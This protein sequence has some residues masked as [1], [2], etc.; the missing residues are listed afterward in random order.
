MTEQ[1]QY[2]EIVFYHTNGIKTIMNYDEENWDIIA[3]NLK[4]TTDG[5]LDYENILIIRQNI[6]SVERR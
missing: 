4:N 1:T 3:H 5:A 2:K 6:T